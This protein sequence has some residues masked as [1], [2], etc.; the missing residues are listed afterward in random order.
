MVGVNNTSFNFADTSSTIASSLDNETSASS[1]SIFGRAMSGLT[2]T[3][4]GLFGG[5]TGGDTIN[6]AQ[7]VTS[8][9]TDNGFADAASVGGMASSIASHSATGISN[10]DITTSENLLLNS[11]NTVDSTASSSVVDA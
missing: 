6:N 3:V 8:I 5:T 10:Y 1:S 2:S 9:I 11:K 7:S 4:F